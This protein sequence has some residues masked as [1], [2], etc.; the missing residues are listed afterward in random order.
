VQI[1]KGD[2]VTKKMSRAHISEPEEQAGYALSCRVIP[3]SNLSL[4]LA[5][6]PADEKTESA[7]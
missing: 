4:R 6:R 5:P 1:V 7:A 3:K 2:Y